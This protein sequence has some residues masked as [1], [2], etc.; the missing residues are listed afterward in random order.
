M[1]ED[2]FYGNINGYDVWYIPVPL[3]PGYYVW[4]GDRFAV[5]ETDTQ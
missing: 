3:P 5:D 4:E 2:I 1:S